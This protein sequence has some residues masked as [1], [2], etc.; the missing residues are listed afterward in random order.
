VSTSSIPSF[1]AEL[2]PTS[3]LLSSYASKL[4]NKNLV[5]AA[6]T[7]QQQPQRAADRQLQ[8]HPASASAPQRRKRQQPRRD[9]GMSSKQ[10]KQHRLFFLPASSSSSSSST[11]LSSSS[12]LPPLRYSSFLPLHRL[13]Q[14]Y[15]AELLSLPHSSLP[16]PHLLMRADHHGAIITVLR[17]VCPTYLH[18]SGIVLQETAETWRIISEDDRQRVLR[19]RGSVVGVDCGSW[20]RLELFGSQLCYRS[21]ERTARKWKGK[22]TVQLEAG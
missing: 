1:L 15:V 9:K 7:Q 8:Q 6:N 13:W 12:S 21:S 4:R 5:L 19:K 16:A 20:G 18:V 11:S 14:Q 17:S 2:L 10:R 22:Q 3:S